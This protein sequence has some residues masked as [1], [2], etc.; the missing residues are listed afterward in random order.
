MCSPDS[1]WVYYILE[2]DE[3]KLTRVPI[4]GGTPQPVSER[5]ISD[6]GFDLS[7]DGNL[8]LSPPWNIPAGIRIS[9][10]WSKPK[11]VRR[12][13]W[14][15][16][17]CALARALQPGRK[18]YRLSPLGKMAWIISGSQ[19]LDGS[20][21]R[22]ITDFSSEHIYDFHWSFD[23]KQLSAGSRPYGLGRGFDPRSEE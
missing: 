8:R 10:Y 20:K 17:D 4:E 14:T 22:Q 3:G 18:G 1:R 23:G 15:L 5:P 13:C 9:W 11:A 16:S 7:P 2:G 19:P 6:S 12:R 21:G